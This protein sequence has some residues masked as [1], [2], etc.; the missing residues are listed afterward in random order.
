MSDVRNSITTKHRQATTTTRALIAPPALSPSFTVT[1]CVSNGGLCRVTAVAHGLKE[2]D[3]IYITAVGGVTGA[4]G[5][6]RINVIDP[7]TFDLEGSTFGGTYTSGGSGFKR[8]V[9]PN[10]APHGVEVYN[11]SGVTAYIGDQTI[12]ADTTDATAGMPVPVGATKWF[13]VADPSVLFSKTASATA[14]L[15]FSYN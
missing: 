14:E 2:N 9:S 4:E 3:D 13:N 10:R 7:N 5:N 1:G 15:H 11:A 6:F 8:N 12:T